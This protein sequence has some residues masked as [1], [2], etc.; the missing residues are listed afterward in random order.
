MSCCFGPETLLECMHVELAI[1]ISGIAEETKELLLNILFSSQRELSVEP[2][3]VCNDLSA[4]R[5][6][7]APDQLRHGV[8]LHSYLWMLFL[9]IVVVIWLLAQVKVVKVSVVL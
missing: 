8:K 6:L 3:K 2:I 5:K 7:H 1:I 9:S 4:S